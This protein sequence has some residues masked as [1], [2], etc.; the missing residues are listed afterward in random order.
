MSSALGLPRVA[1]SPWRSKVVWAKLRLALVAISLGLGVTVTAASAQI[2]VT[3]AWEPNTDGLTAGYRVFVGTSP[4]VPL[5]DID[6][7]AATSIALPLPVGNVYYVAVRGYTTQG[8]LGPASAEAIVDL[9]APPG[10]PESFRASI[11]GPSAVLDWWPPLSGGLASNYLLS[12][13]TS[14]GAVNLLNQLPVGAVQSVGGDLPPGVYYARLHALNLVG[15]G[16]PAEMSFEVGGGYR[17]VGPSGLTAAVSGTNVHLT[18]SAPSAPAAEMPTSYHLEAGSAPGLS[19]LVSVNVGNVTSFTAAV[20]PGTY[21]VRVRG[22]SA[23]G[24][25][26]ASGEVLVQAQVGIPTSAPRNLRAT[27]SGAVVTLSWSEPSTGSAK[28]YVLEAGSVSAASDLAAI[29]V[30][31]VTSFTASLPVGTYYV[32]V[33]ALNSA[34]LSAPSNQIV[35]RPR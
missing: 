34:G 16:P 32:R 30:G 31:T 21:Y 5:A 35:V 19:N 15:V 10:R 12:V 2:R 11:N 29:N 22:V 1:A 3:A 27:T 26:D 33:R 9:S 25:S 13:G 24:V 20:P 6:V 17:P 7:G 14:P 4:G 18:W 28:A 23:R 8:A